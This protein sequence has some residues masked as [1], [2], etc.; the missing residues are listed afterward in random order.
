M[1]SFT[2]FTDRR[3]HL[4]TLVGMERMY[5][6]SRHARKTETYVAVNAIAF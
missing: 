2:V 1:S 3:P 4:P 6:Y 5:T